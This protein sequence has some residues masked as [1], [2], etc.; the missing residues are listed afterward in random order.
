MGHGPEAAAVMVQLRTA[1]HVLAALD[2]RPEQML[3]RLDAMA[4][5]LAAPFAASAPAPSSTRQPAPA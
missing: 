5:G 4:A 1:A 3:R 2:L